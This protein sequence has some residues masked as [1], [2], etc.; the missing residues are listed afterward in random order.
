[1]DTLFLSLTRD[2]LGW[3]FLKVL[4]DT[5]GDAPTNE[6]ELGHGRGQALKLYAS[7]ATKRIEE[8]LRVSVE[9][10]LVCHVDCE[11]LSV[12]RSV[13]DV[14]CLGIIGDKPLELT[15]G[16][17]FARLTENVVK[18]LTILWYFVEPLEALEQNLGLGHY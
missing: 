14:L 18:L 13:R 2:L 8:L 6:V 7:R 17:R 11:H 1:M 10:R 5:V 15:Q 4:N 16:G 9:A 12:R 3:R